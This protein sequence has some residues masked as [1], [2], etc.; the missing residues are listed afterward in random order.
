MGDAT[1][2]A[3]IGAKY[4]VLVY[5]DGQSS[6]P[7]AY[8]FPGTGTTEYYST[9]Q[10]GP[11][12]LSLPAGDYQVKVVAFNPNTAAGSEPASAVSGK[13]TGELAAQK[14]ACMFD[15]LSPGWLLPL[16]LG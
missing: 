4:R 1:L 8:T 16:A 7:P 3:E 14:A 9:T 12:D 5:A 2:M 6:S 10:P 11:H 15:W 13:V